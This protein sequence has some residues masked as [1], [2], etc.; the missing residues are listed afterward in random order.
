MDREIQRSG[1]SFPI[2]VSYLNYTFLRLQELGRIAFSEDGAR[3]CFNTG[4]QTPNEKDIFA[5]F[6]RNRQAEERD[7]PDWTLYG[8][9]DSYSEKLV[10]FRPLPEVASYVDD[11]AVSL[12]S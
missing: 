10:D 11:P 3:A 12:S 8:F 6:Y 1:Q 9:F 4:L 2:L 5:T 7:Q